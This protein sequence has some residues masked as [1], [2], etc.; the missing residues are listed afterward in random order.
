MI[1]PLLT[2]F[3][4][5]AAA[6]LSAQTGL[7]VQW[8]FSS[9]KMNATTYEIHLTAKMDENWHIYSQ[10]TPD[11]GPTPTSISFLKNPLLSLQG[12]VQEVGKMEKHFERLFGVE[13]RQFS[14]KVDFVQT[15]VVKGKVKTALNGTVSFM[16]CNDEE[17][18]PAKALKFS[19]PVGGK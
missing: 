4:L 9:K 13:V 8:N 17:C 14:G 7:P 15:V 1:K 3:A 18:L 16:T 6:T 11:G 5:V 10:S 19:I 2:L 12:Q